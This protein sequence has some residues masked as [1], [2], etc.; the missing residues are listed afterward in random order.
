MNTYIIEYDH[1]AGA[2]AT[3]AFVEGIHDHTDD[4][5]AM[6]GSTQFFATLE[7]ASR[8]ILAW[9][10][11]AD[12]RPYMAPPSP[13][14]V[15]IWEDFGEFLVNTPERQVVTHSLTDALTIVHTVTNTF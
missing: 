15:V 13:D 14:D 2:W 8:R 3:Y 9:K 4:S 11:L 10:A 1:D 6:G 7:E 12:M 5:E